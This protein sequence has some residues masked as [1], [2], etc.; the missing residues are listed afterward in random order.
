MTD[1]VLTSGI[2]SAC[3]PEGVLLSSSAVFSAPRFLVVLPDHQFRFRKRQ[4]P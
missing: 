4:R 3:V 1:T 2:L